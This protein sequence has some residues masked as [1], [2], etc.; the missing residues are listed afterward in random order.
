MNPNIME[1]REG[2]KCH[3]IIDLLWFKIIFQKIKKT[4]KFANAHRRNGK[5]YWCI[6]LF[7]PF[8]FRWM[9]LMIFFVIFPWSYFHLDFRQGWSLHSLPLSLSILHFQ[10]AHNVLMHSTQN[11]FFG[12]KSISIKFNI[13]YF[14]FGVMVR[15]IVYT[16]R[17][18]M[19]TFWQKKPP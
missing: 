1:I 8:S 14:V 19:M 4:R 7:F 6:S 2:K 12:G 5:G 11:G 16:H 13:I 9:G 18:R 17:F 10:C 3:R 15:P